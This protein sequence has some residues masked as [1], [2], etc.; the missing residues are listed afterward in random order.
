MKLFGFAL[1]FVLVSSVVLFAEER[2][3]SWNLMT[4]AGYEFLSFDDQK[5]HAPGEGIMFTMGDMD[6]P[7]SEPRNSFVIM[8]MA[9]QFFLQESQNGY[10]D[11]YHSMSVMAEKRIGRHSIIALAVSETDKPFY[12]GLRSFI[13]GAGYGYEFIRKENMSLLL[14]IDAALMDSGIDLPNG[15]PFPVMVLPRILFHA[16]TSWLDFSLEFLNQPQIGVTLFPH[17][18]LR[19]INAVV[20]P[21]SFRD[22]RDLVFDTMLMYRFF[23][24]ES[25]MGDFAGVGIGFKNSGFGSTLAEK[26]K[27]YDIL[28]HSVYGKVD[29]SFLQITGG[30]L[31]NGVESYDSDRRKD[32]G[33][34]FYADVM[35]GWQF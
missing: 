8:G 10:A 27:T 23:S 35:L 9:K 32:I 12:G 2:S 25:R 7:V 33:G 19:L 29:L 3:K 17:A 11:V 22:E 28:Y 6:P 14:G 34:G 13:A 30:Y 18:K 1:L 21:M 20:V 31:F 5:I 26:D 15:D 16:E 24:E 4:M